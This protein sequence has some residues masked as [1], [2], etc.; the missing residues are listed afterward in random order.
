MSDR[1]LKKILYVEDDFS[2]AEVVCMTLEDFGD[3]DIIHCDLGQKALDVVADFQP[4]LILMDVMMPHMDG[5]TTLKHFQKMPEA[6]N[7]PVVFMTA[8]AQV[9]EQAEYIDLG[10]I[11]VLVKPFDPMTL[12]DDLEALWRKSLDKA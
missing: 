5:P 8:K 4:D 2:I 12:C 1:S 9:H 10:A 7:I 3:Y 11:G 6:Q